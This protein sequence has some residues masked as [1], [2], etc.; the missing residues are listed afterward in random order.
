MKFVDEFRNPEQSRALLRRIKATATREWVLMEVCGGQTHGLLRYGI[1]VELSG[2]IELIH[3]P[4]CPVCVTDIAAIDHAVDLA[5][6]PHVLL[7]SFGDMLRVPGS[8]GSLLTARANGANV[9]MVYSPLD[10]VRYAESHPSEHVV[11]FAVGFE[12]TTPATALAVLQAQRLGLNNFSVLAS[13]VR[14]LPAMEALIQ[15]PQNRVQGFLAAGH[16]CCITGYSDYEEFVRRFHIPVV[17]TGFE[18]IDLLQ[19]ILDCVTQLESGSAEVHNTYSRSVDRNG[20][21]HA[22]DVI[23]SVYEIDTRVW[24]GLG[25]VDSGGY[26]IR[27]ELQQFD[28]LQRFNLKAVEQNE[29][30]PSDEL[31]SRCRAGEVLTGRLKPC[32][33]PEFRKACTPE[34]PLG[35]PMVSS[36]GACAAYEKFHPRATL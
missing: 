25:P 29:I 9:L 33:C 18:T 22:R 31:Q 15:A 16:V 1:D 28:A 13:H 19:G 3:G 11:F 12:T 23:G 35:A 27:R 26:A 34:T 10:A 20:N 36:E 24:R 2:V 7:A 32:D 5:H 14:V 4:G 30:N 17:V 21:R 8:C 6:R